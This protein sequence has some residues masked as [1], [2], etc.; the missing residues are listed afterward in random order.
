MENLSLICSDCKSENLCEDFVGIFAE[1]LFSKKEMK[2]YESTK[3]DL[4][5]HLRKLT[6]SNVPI[7]LNTV[8]TTLVNFNLIQ[9][10]DNNELIRNINVAIYETMSKAE[11][12]KDCFELSEQSKKSITKPYDIKTLSAY[13]INKCIDDNTPLNYL[14]LVKVVFFVDLEHYKTKGATLTNG[15]F[16]KTQHGAFNE[17]I[18]AE[19]KHKIDNPITTKVSTTKILDVIAGE[20]KFVEKQLF[21]ELIENEDIVF[22]DKIVDKYKT[23]S[24]WELRKLSL[25]TLDDLELNEV[26]DYENI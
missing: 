5:R 18:H 7:N 24:T 14:Q 21:P 22:I 6:R 20:F 13:V 9:V 19:F 3:D 11:K 2:Q 26:V 17:E 16:T 25:Q 15:F 4:K 23:M 10:K 12:V 8:I 1:I